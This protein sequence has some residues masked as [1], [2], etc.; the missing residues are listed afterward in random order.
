MDQLGLNTNRWIN[1]TLEISAID[2]GKSG[3]MTNYTH[4]QQLAEMKKELEAH[5]ELATNRLQEL[6]KLHK[7]HLED[8]KEVEKLKN[9][10][11]TDLC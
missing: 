5:R 1:F 9:D 2:N 4:T 3:G 8:V 6:D 10:V 7:Q 11:S